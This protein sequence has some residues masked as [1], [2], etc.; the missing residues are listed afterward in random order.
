MILSKHTNYE[1]RSYIYCVISKLVCEIISFKNII[2]GL[3]GSCVITNI[4]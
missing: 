3:V 2:R 1:P 4:A